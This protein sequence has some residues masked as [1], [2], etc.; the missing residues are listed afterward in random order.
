VLPIQEWELTGARADLREVLMT[1]TAE[2]RRPVQSL[3]ASGGGR[4]TQMVSLGSVVCRLA[5]SGEKPEDLIA[6]EGR[7]TETWWDLSLPVGT[8]VQTNDQFII[9][10]QAYEVV[11]GEGEET[12][13]LAVYVRCRLL[14]GLIAPILLPNRVAS[15]AAVAS[16]TLLRGIFFFPGPV[17]ATAAVRSATLVVG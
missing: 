15:A 5:A 1:G 6:G 16:A 17:S 4:R 7:R 10:Y 2:H 11:D 13:A 8:V 3:S 14:K 9:N 12:D